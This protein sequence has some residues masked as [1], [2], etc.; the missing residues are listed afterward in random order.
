MSRQS[1][2]KQS[3][4]SSDT[5]KKR[6]LFIGSAC[7]C[8]VYLIA[9]YLV[10]FTGLFA[11][12]Y[13]RAN[14]Q[15][16]TT[17]ASTTPAAIA[18]PVLN[19]AAYNAK[20]LSVANEPVA[21]VSST[22][23]STAPVSKKLWP[24]KTVYPL[25]GAL[26]P[27]HRIVAYYGNFYSTKMGVLGEYPP[28]QML[29]MLNAEVAKWNAADPSTPVIPAIDY[30]AITAQGSPGADGMY[31][32]RMPDSQI[33]EALTLANEEHGLV[34][35]DI[36]VGLSTVQTEVPLLKKYLM[37]PNVELALDPEFS[38]KDGAKPGT[39]IGTMDAS[40][41]NFSANYL[42]GLV[43]ANN[44]PPKI[45]VVHRF[46]QDMVTRTQD[47]TP[48]PQVQIVMD[49]DGWGSP[50]KKINTYQQFIALQPV[51]FT[52]F[53]L[54]YVNDL[55]APSTRM[56]TPAELLKLTPQ[57]LFIQYQ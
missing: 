37:L 23:S 6:L 43:T 11:V 9:L 42:A 26:L 19:I 50:A 48:L 21:K 17:S 27:F 22:S 1:S 46:T 52:G 38:M 33:Q 10:G 30:I 41:I 47:I 56:L 20:L 36:Q 7:V 29:P 15:A 13:D 54:F 28:A 49:M 4:E 35:L 18:I 53:K 31:R 8:G 3:Q 5:G 45:L 55:R 25:P 39:E 34:I 57:P 51:E 40:D 32:A 16:T 14:A 44:L 24:V 2:K 12:E